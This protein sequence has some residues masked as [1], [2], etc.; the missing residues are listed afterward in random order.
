[1]IN[2]IIFTIYHI[3]FSNFNCY[4][5]IK[6]T[7]INIINYFH[8]LFLFFINKVINYLLIHPFLFIFIKFHWLLILQNLFTYNDLNLLINYFNFI[9]SNLSKYITLNYQCFSKL[10]NYL[11]FMHLINNFIKTQILEFNI[12][13]I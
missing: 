5:L 3:Y 13:S 12:V 7:L 1:M 10:I 6:F 11:L 9:I 2:L 4:F 8:I